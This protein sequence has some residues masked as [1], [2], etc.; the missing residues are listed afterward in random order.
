MFEFIKVITLRATYECQQEG[1][2][3]SYLGSTIRGILG[4]CIRDFCCEYQSE[5]CYQCEKKEACLYVQCF[6][7]TGGEAG[8]VNPYTLYVHGEGRGTW[9]KGD[10]CVFDLML[11]GRGA[12]QA[13]IYLDALQAA[14]QKGWGAA[15]F[16]FRLIQVIDPDSEKLIYSGGKIWMRNLSPRPLQITERNASYA[17]LFFDTPLRII[18]GDRLFEKLTFDVLM[19]F[20]IR[21]ISLLT[22]AYTDFQLE[23]DEEGLLEEARKVRTV[24]EYWREIPFSRYS[25]NQ[26]NCRLDLP[27][28]T[29]WVMYEG[30]LSKFVPIL[31]AGRYLRLGKGATIGFGHYEITYDR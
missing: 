7:N 20:L 9:K 19:Q 12:D 22:M 8:A 11:F 2:L 29:G 15:R 13:G 10:V 17:N 27:S 5:R 18:S 24:S 21:R 26:K 28:K 14:E 31:E 6:S 4:H 30:D 3:P 16:S 25:M 23:W 1:R